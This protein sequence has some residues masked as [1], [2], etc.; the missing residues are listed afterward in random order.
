MALLAMR[1]LVFVIPAVAPMTKLNE[2]VDV[3]TVLTTDIGKLGALRL[4]AA[5]LAA[6]SA[7]LVIAYPV[8]QAS[9]A[10]I[11][12]YPTRMPLS[13]LSFGDSH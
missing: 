13:C 9:V 12:T 6:A 3:S 11:V 5:V 4:S 1:D 2:I 7:Y 10:N 8:V